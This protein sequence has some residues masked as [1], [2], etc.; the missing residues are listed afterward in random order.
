[1]P[2]STSWCS[3]TWNG[4][5]FCAVSGGSSTSSIAAT[6]T[7]GI[8]W[9]QRTLPVVTNWFS[10]VWNGNVFCAVA[11]SS[12]IAAISPNGINWTQQILPANTGWA[13]QA[14]NGSVISVLARNTSIAATITTYP[15]TFSTPTFTGTLGISNAAWY[16]KT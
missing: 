13:A 4:S 7:D 14:Y 15:A 2:V 12:T 3:I 9:T 11:Y 1:M 8:N 16:I 6:S 5:L 10:V